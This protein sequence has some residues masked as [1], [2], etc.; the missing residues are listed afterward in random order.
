M[1]LIFSLPLSWQASAER[2]RFVKDEKDKL[3]SGER[4][5]MIKLL[6]LLF[7]VDS[8]DSAKKKKNLK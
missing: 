8:L 7:L 1:R 5:N 3:T 6:L 4:K 2:N